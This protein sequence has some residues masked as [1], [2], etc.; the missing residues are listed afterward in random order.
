MQVIGRACSPLLDATFWIFWQFYITFHLATYEVMVDATGEAQV[1]EGFG[2][3]DFSNP[4]WQTLYVWWEQDPHQPI[5][6]NTVLDN[7][8]QLFFQAGIETL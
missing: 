7:L 5:S 2:Q 3:P 1:K 4:E 8:N 6:A